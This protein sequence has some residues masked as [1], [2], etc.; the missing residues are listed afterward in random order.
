MEWFFDGLGTELISVIIGI[1][2]G[3]VTGGTI[4]YKIGVNK[5]S[6][7]QEQ[8]AGTASKQRQIGERDKTI[9]HHHCN[10]CDISTTSVLRASHIKEWAQSSKEERIDANNGLLLCANIYLQDTYSIPVLFHCI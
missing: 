5:Q 2:F 6:V 7:K 3:A 1:I 8:K 4:G 9:E 10:L